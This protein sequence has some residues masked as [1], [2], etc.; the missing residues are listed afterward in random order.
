MRAKILDT[1][2]VKVT[3]KLFGGFG[4]NQFEPLNKPS[5][6]Q[7]APAPEPSILDRIKAH[8]GYGKCEVCKTDN[9]ILSGLK[10]DEC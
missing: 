8:S 5:A 2:S 9:C 3:L 6:P 1:P 10:E 7:A 4:M